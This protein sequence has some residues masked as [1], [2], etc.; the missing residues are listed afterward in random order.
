M[1]LTDRQRK[2]LFAG[3][4]VVLVAAGVFLTIGNGGGRGPARARHRGSPRAS[5]PA[6]PTTSAAPVT[7]PTPSPGSYDLYSM[8]GLGQQDFNVAADVS[9]R[10]VV[11]YGTYRFDEDPKVYAGRLQGIAAPDVVAQLQRD[12]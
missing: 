11:A 7:G 2:L 5:S 9:R 3:L 1:D 8:L 12:S 6:P 4:V 10:F